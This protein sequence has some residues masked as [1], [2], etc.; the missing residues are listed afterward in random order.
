MKRLIRTWIYYT[1]AIYL[2]GELIPGFK[3][4][5]DLRGLLLSG[6][7]LA[8]LFNFVNPILKFLFL[9]INMLTLGL[10]TFVSQV[11]TFY[12]F[13]GLWPDYFQIKT[14][15]FSGLILSGLGI[16]INPFTVSKLLTIIL[17][18]G[19]ISIIMS[20]LLMLI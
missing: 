9:P 19:L 2:V 5:T 8:L 3:I 6:L 18:T 7:S 20:V 16:N 10:F 14:W 11:L 13:L 4:S 15:E 1:L 17:S 12:L